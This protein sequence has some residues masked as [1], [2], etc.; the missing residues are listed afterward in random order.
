MWL[1]TS[2]GFVS[3][4][5]DS[6][7]PDQLIVRSRDRRSLEPL[8]ALDGAPIIVGAGTDYPYRLVC[9]RATFAG[10]VASEIGRVDY[11]NFKDRVHQVRGDRFS[12][13]LMS[14]WSAMHDVT[15]A[16][17]SRW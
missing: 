2:G 14:V 13:A 16:E 9:A 1:F 12:D 15:D 11:G 6:A 17:G 8:A 5:A 3:A 10:W 4:V 7:N